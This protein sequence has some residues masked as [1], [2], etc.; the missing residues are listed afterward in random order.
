MDCDDDENVSG[1]EVGVLWIA[2]GLIR[3]ERKGEGDGDGP[4]DWPSSNRVARREIKSG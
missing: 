3:S 2:M 4:P 1:G